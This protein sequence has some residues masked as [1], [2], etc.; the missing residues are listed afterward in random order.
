[1][2]GK[3]GRLDIKEI[4]NR[5]IHVPDCSSAPCLMPMKERSEGRGLT[6]TMSSP[7]CRFL[8]AC[9]LEAAIRLVDALAMAICT[10]Y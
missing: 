4:R 5:N 3:N 2:R 10:R 8:R 6:L 7:S 9:S 1:M